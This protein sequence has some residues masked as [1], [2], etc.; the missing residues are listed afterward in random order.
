MLCAKRWKAAQV[1]EADVQ[2]LRASMDAHDAREGLYLSLGKANQ[3]AQEFAALN[4][5]AILNNAPL[6]EFVAGRNR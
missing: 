4:R 6:A 2:A 3:K 1:S 5:I